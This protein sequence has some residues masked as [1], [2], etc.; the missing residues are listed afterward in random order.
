[1]GFT[2]DALVNVYVAPR[3]GFD[4]IFFRVFA[5][6]FVEHDVFPLGYGPPCGGPGGLLL[7]PG[8]AQVL[9]KDHIACR[10]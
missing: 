1:M 3:M 4:E 8:A 5:M 7:P 10:L 9:F 2:G 6:V